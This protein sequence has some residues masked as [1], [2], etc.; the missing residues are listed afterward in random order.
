[1]V[2]HSFA[3]YSLI[4]ELYTVWSNGKK[5]YTVW[6]G[7]STNFFKGLCRLVVAQIVLITLGFQS[8]VKTHLQCGPVVD[9]LIIT[10][11]SGHIVE[12]DVIPGLVFSIRS[13]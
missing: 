7:G 5:F 3:Q 8:G 12:Q 4:A 10:L 11:R 9:K 1:M 2:K 6:S 13:L